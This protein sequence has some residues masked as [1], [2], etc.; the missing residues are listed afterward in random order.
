M[1][2]YGKSLAVF[3]FPLLAL[4]ILGCAVS[5]PT[6]RFAHWV[7]ITMV[8]FYVGHAVIMY[9]LVRFIFPVMPMLFAFAAMG[10][11]WLAG[12]FIPRLRT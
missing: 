6:W 9:P 11:F 2:H 10:I 5:W 8:A 3:H 4:F 12:R 7:L 1:G